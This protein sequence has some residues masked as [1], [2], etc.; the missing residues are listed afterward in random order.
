MFEELDVDHSLALSRD[1]VI[2][3]YNVY[4]LLIETWLNKKVMLLPSGIGAED[5]V[6]RFGSGALE[7]ELTHLM[8]NRIHVEEVAAALT[9]PVLQSSWESRFA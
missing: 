6:N 1:E 9:G 7:C 5:K 4:P 2:T 8:R 3:V